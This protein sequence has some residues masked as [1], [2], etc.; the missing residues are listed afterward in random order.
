MSS[1]KEEKSSSFDVVLKEESG[2]SDV[3]GVAPC[4]EMRCFLLLL[5]GKEYS[6]VVLRV[7]VVDEV[8]SEGTGGMGIGWRKEE[9]R[10]WIAGECV[11]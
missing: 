7:I 4:F 2:A 5:E 1:I 3:D 11:S 10:Y 8:V 6:E 9:E